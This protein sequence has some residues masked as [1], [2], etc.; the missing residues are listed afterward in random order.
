ME[1][2]WMLAYPDAEMKPPDRVMAVQTPRR[3]KKG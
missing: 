2:I 3:G 1:C